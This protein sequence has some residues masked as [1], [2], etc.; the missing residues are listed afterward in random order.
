MP[1][2]IVKLYGLPDDRPLLAGLADGGI[3]IRK[4][5]AYEKFQVA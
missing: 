4:A 3:T 5:M 1:D 2:L